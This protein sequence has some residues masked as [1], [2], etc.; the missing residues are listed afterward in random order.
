METKKEKVKL[1]ILFQ[2]EEAREIDLLHPELGNPGVGGTAFCFILLMK[3]LDL[4]PEI[5]MTVY[6]F[7]KNNLPCQNCKYVS[8]I[9]EALGEIE[10]DK[11]EVVL[12]R[13]HQEDSV[14]EA[15]K[16]HA[17][18]YIVW[19]HN[20]LSYPE[21]KL[22]SEMKSVRRIISVSR[23]M[24]DYYIDDTII[25]KMDYIWNIFVPPSKEKVRGSNQTKNVTFMGSLTYD[26]N[27]HL[28]TDV[29]KRIVE[30]V[31]TAKL[32][33][34]GSGKLYDKHSVMGKYGIAEKE[35]EE[36][37]MPGICDDSGNVLD[38][39]VFHGIL[40]DEKYDVMKESA[41]G[42]ANPMA[43]ETFCLV[44][45]EMEACG[46][47]VVSRRKNGLVDTVK[48]GETGILYS[49]IS[50]L[51]TAIIQLL[52]DEEL[53]ET[54]GEKAKE[55]ARNFFLPE[56]IIPKWILIM[57]QVAANEPARYQKPEQ[58]FDNNGKRIRQI[59]HG[60]HR[61]PFLRWVP[62]IH[63]LQKK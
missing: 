29:W 26:K 14:Y 39:V 61:I 63:D 55:F 58:N 53:N 43:T 23:E 35:Y 46:V 28:L 50:E 10:K 37:F 8:S 3:Y 2:E 47:P 7:Q 59:L 56:N 42:V 27:F 9:E 48:S 38:S 62:S 30:E 36:R 60:I 1:A 49:D 51:P 33:V 22:F 34:I 17:L 24:Y 5:D 4:R 25:E 21:I 18:K 31:P 44:A 6:S 45:I 11:K 54:M 32:H 19:M 13:N 15:L 52:K 12:L 40:G 20:K 57:Q 41:V 16:K